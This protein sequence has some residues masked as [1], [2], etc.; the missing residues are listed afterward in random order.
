MSRGLLRTVLCFNLDQRSHRGS[1]PLSRPLTLSAC[2]PEVTSLAEH[3]RPTTV[4]LHRV[5][6]GCIHTDHIQPCR[7]IDFKETVSYGLCGPRAAEHRS[8]VSDLGAWTRN[9]CT[10]MPKGICA[11]CATLHHGKAVDTMPRRVASP[12]KP[13]RV[14]ACQARARV[15]GFDTA[16]HGSPAPVV[17]WMRP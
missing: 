10:S 17:G 8:R 13:W 12:I 5:A 16:R 6:Q 1:D 7:L 11:F 14:R 15:L 2:N 4:A 9:L 3:T